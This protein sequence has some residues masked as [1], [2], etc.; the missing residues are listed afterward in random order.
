MIRL[1]LTNA[2]KAAGLD[3]IPV[4]VADDAFLRDLASLPDRYQ[5]RTGADDLG[6]PATPHS[7]ANPSRG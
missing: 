4:V 1:G 6:A 7:A 5:P 3:G 2:E